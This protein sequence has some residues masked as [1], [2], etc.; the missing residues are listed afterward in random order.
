MTTTT[1]LLLAILGQQPPPP[2]LGALA[3]AVNQLRCDVDALKAKLDACPKGAPCPAGGCSTP[4]QCGHAGCACV[5]AKA[6]TAPQLW[7][8]TDCTGTVCTDYS[9]ALVTA[10]VAQRN[11][12]YSHYAA[13]PPVLFQGFGGFG[14]PLLGGG[15]SCASGA[16]GFN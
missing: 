4:G 14:G 12:Y 7:K 6:A 10:R 1:V 16:C 11:A 13:P 3:T 9:P 8:L 2:D 15:G 5:A